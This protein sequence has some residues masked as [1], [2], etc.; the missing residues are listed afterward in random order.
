[1]SLATKS[2]TTVGYI[3]E[4]TDGTTPANPAFKQLR[5]TGEDL[6]V[7]RDYGF[8]N[9]L[10]GRRGQKNSALLR[11]GGGGSLKFEF[12]DATLDDMLEGALRNTWAANVLTDAN[13]A[14]PFTFEV[15]HE[16]GAADV[17]KR[18]VGCQVGGLK[19]SAAAQQVVSGEL[20]IV[21]RGGVYANAIVAGAT[22]VAPNA[23]PVE[24]GPTVGAL[25]FA[26]LTIGIVSKIDLELKNNLQ[27]IY[28]LGA[29]TPYGLPAS[30]LEVTANLEIILD[31]VEFDVLTAHMNGTL[32]GLDFLIGS[33]TLK[34]TRFEVPSMRI[35]K[36]S[37]NADSADGIVMAS[38]ALRGLQSAAI[39]QSVIRV[40][41]DVA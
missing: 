41:R 12:S 9:E 20:E 10:D 4:V 29:A 17:F 14:K 19:I 8:S 25:A 15:R 21:S 38:L 3:A 16:T 35:E 36:L 30:L 28:G 18:F 7:T 2:Q 22:Y 11:S 39:A 24:S 34:K 23:E 27:A 37:A 33:T 6:E 40:T 32:T 26:G 31:D 1:M 13:V 5:V